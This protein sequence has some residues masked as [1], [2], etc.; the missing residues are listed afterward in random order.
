MSTPPPSSS[1]LVLPATSSI[2]L[3]TLFPLALLR[4]RRSIQH[5]TLLTTITLAST[6]ALTLAASFALVALVNKDRERTW[7]L[8]GGTLACVALILLDLSTFSLA[9]TLGECARPADARQPRTRS[10]LSLF[11]LALLS[12]LVLASTTLQVALLCLP[13][14]PYSNLKTLAIARGVLHALFEGVVVLWGMRKSRMREKEREVEEARL[15]SQGWRDVSSL[16]TRHVEAAGDGLASSKNR[17]L[18]LAFLALQLLAL[19]LDILSAAFPLRTSL[20]DESGQVPQLLLFGRASSPV[21]IVVMAAVGWV[22]WMGMVEVIAAL[23][24][25]TRST[26]LPAIITHPDST[27]YH[28]PSS[29]PPTPTAASSL[30][31]L[32][33]LP[34]KRPSP[35][36]EPLLSAHARES[37]SMEKSDVTSTPGQGSF[38]SSFLLLEAEADEVGTYEPTSAQV[39][40]ATEVGHR[41]ED[42]VVVPSL[43]VRQAG[44]LSP[45]LPPMMALPLLTTPTGSP[46]SRHHP[47]RSLPTLLTGDAPSRPFTPV[48]TPVRPNDERSSPFEGPNLARSGSNSPILARWRPLRSSEDKS[49]PPPSPTTGK[50]SAPPSP[51][52]LR[53]GRD[54]SVSSAPTLSLGLPASS[55]ADKRAET[56]ASCISRATGRRRSGSVGSI[57]RSFT[58]GTGGRPSMETKASVSAGPSLWWDVEPNEEEDDPFVRSAPAPPLPSSSVSM[59]R[60]STDG[61]PS[62][63]EGNGAVTPLR[64]KK[65]LLEAIQEPDGGDAALASPARRLDDDEM[66]RMLT[67]PPAHGEEFDP[68]DHKNSPS[69]ASSIAYAYRAR[70]ASQSS[71]GSV[72]REHLISSDGD[73][74]SMPPP[75]PSSS[76]ALSTFAAFGGG[77]LPSSPVLA[78]RRRTDAMISPLVLPRRMNSEGANE[79]STAP[80]ISSPTVVSTRTSSPSITPK[81]SRF[82]RRLSRQKR[83]S[84]LSLR[85]NSAFSSSPA[86]NATP[87]RRSPSSS[88]LPTRSSTVSASSNSLFSSPAFASL[89]RITTPRRPPSPVPS[90]RPSE[91]SDLSFACRGLVDSSSDFNVS[92]ANII[93][94]LL[95]PARPSNAEDEVERVE[96]PSSVRTKYRSR[97]SKGNRNAWWKQIPSGS[98]P[99][100]LYRSDSRASP[101]VRRTSAPARSSGSYSRPPSYASGSST[102]RYFQSAAIEAGTPGQLP[103]HSRSVSLPLSLPPVPAPSSR[104]QLP[105]INDVSPIGSS[106][107]HLPSRLSGGSPRSNR[108]RSGQK[109]SSRIAVPV[110]MPSASFANQ[111]VLVETSSYDTA[112]TSPDCAIA[113]ERFLTTPTPEPLA[114]ELHELTTLVRRFAGSD[115]ADIWTSDGSAT[116]TSTISSLPFTPL[117]PVFSLDP[118]SPTLTYSRA[119]HTRDDGDAEEEIELMS[120]L[121]PASPC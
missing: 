66:E 109:S 101:R 80:Q 100:N 106:I 107:F 87:Q 60:T 71:S 33:D 88:V 23:S 121:T 7:T 86:G 96:L 68:R 117:S 92:V 15:P 99:T 97:T 54:A 43:P 116:P 120:P 49:S 114:H 35:R 52:K 36:N 119:R 73:T 118:G 103:G 61:E 82:P 51:R 93:P 64:L 53:R 48:W 20:N 4:L 62:T 3:L 32:T 46:I 78:P 55:E 110:T 24:S 113:G 91:S 42:L 112:N 75:S 14:L 47:R 29:L 105:A 31:P 2:L 34:P 111:Q 65:A 41:E 16:S 69:A 12:T 70:S 85:S 27:C 76:L 90:N 95:I 6:L 58:A 50:T 19:A 17:S 11:L 37:Q 104:F 21:G 9:H 84:I 72:F 38:G 79:P 22:K 59:S 26:A 57:L 13:S 94:P 77:S 89:R 67:P 18:S 108:S 45:S 115:S 10:F 81:A 102:P 98:R 74:S 40:S 30:R 39:S 25:A 83:P 63:D 1:S 5:P 28:N 8:L 44:R 56:P